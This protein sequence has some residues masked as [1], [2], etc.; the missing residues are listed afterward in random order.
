[1]AEDLSIGETPAAS[2]HYPRWVLKGRVNGAAPRVGWLDKA[3]YLAVLAVVF[4]S[5]MNFLRLPI[6]YFTLSDAFACV[7]LIL[8]LVNRTLPT[9]PLG[10]LWSSVWSAGFIVF[11]ISLLVSSLVNGDPF[12]GM[13]LIA[14]YLFSYFLLLAIIV[15]RPLKQTTGLVWVYVLS[16]F[17]MCLHGIYL[18]NW[19][20]RTNTTFVSG[21]GRLTG[22]V[23]RE[24]ECGAVI[25]MAMS[26]LLWLVS[27]GRLPKLALIVALP[28]MLYAVMLTGSNTALGAFAFALTIYMLATLTW[29]RAALYAGGALG[30][31]AMLAA[32]ARDLLPAVFQK[33]VLGALETGDLAQAGSFDHRLALIYEALDRA[34]NTILLGVGADQYQIKSF[35]YQP[36]HNLYLLLWTE[37]GLLCVI[38]F[39]VMLLSGFGPAA[40]ALK[41]RGGWIYA[42]CTFCMISMFLL[43]VNAFPHVY[44]R[45][46]AVPVLLA[47]AVSVAYVREG[48]RR[49]LPTRF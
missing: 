37:G 9:R 49:L 31:I 16:V 27:S 22:F 38:G 15:G 40:T 32:H 39:L 48:T 6:F 29:F 20:G 44:G 46:W 28:I 12:R 35:L 25:A 10:A 17:L 14:Q 34:N 43:F 13:I 7:C 33:R 45:F 47:I 36:V 41:T 3:E 1:M 26:L 30:A 19:D 18:V 11:T 8:M 2:R 4:L 23:E 42:V 21:S 5:P 24:N